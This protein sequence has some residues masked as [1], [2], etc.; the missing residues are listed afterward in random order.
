MK[1]LLT[2]AFGNIGRYVL[3]ELLGRGY[4]VRCFEIKTDRNKAWAQKYKGRA[5]VIWGDLRKIDDV[6][7]AVKGCDVII[8][9]AY[10]IP[11]LSEKRPSWAYE[12]NVG[13]TSNIIRAAHRQQKL[14][15]IIFTSSI[16]VYGNTQ[17]MPPP[18]RVADPVNPL[19]NY[20]RQ[21]LACEKLVKESGLEWAIL[22]LA[23]APSI[24]LERIDPIM[25][26]ISLEDRIEFI[27]PRDIAKAVVNA[28]D[29]E[30]VWGK[31]LLIGGG[32]Q[33][34]MLQRIFMEKCLKM[35]G[36][37]MLPDSAFARHHYH[38]DWMDTGESQRILKYQRHSFDD[39]LKE[40]AR[41]FGWRVWLMRLFR[42]IIR[43]IL[44]S[45]S[46]YYKQL[47]QGE[48]GRQGYEV[49]Q[50]SVWKGK[51]AI[52]TGASSGI[53]A[54]VA[55][56]LAHEGIIVVLVARRRERLDEL[57]ATLSCQGGEAMVIAADLSQE[58]DR[59]KVLCEAKARYG[60]V[61]MLINCAGFGW[62][63]F[64]FE[65][66][67]KTARDML[68]VN[69]ASSVHLA[70]LLLPEMKSRKSGFIINVGSIAGSLPSQGIAVYS[71]TKAF[72]DS[73]TKSLIRE[74]KGSGV[75]V[76]VVKPGPV[77]TE[78]YNSAAQKY[79]SLPIPAE[80]FGISAEKVAERIWQMIKRR[81]K[82]AYIPCFLALTPW[83][84]LLCGWIMNLLGPVLLRRRSSSQA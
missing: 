71:A 12:I 84:E 35:L 9:L 62:Y 56:R 61:D 44:L 76:G 7:R 32:E 4:D 50:H 30:E 5:E 10:I 29:A 45:K 55:K 75:H 41:I 40:Q 19:D 73:F 54:A 52:V 74:L 23:A 6:L 38:T 3:D 27:H 70:L 78:F 14:P 67:W 8:H 66:P 57:A 64:G 47:L 60:K 1:I 69:V 2:G 24:D 72:I 16:A 15:K 58:E 59:C 48:H 20:G 49:Y 39:F 63:G 13:G 77:A 37:E 46:P 43:R 36:I 42:P 31:T 79:A 11:P 22:R 83:V 26:E 81:Q 82:I 28:V 80:R 21:K 34:R 17:H 33:C 68:A 25:F 18:R 51:V 53:G 65:M